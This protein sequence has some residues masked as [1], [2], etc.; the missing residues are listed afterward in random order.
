LAGRKKIIRRKA[1]AVAHCPHIEGLRLQDLFLWLQQHQEPRDYLPAE[2][3]LVKVGK[4]WLCNILSTVLP[5][6]F[7]DFV[8]QQID[9]RQEKHT[10]KQNKQVSICSLLHLP[11]RH[12]T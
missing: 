11:A 6:A 12:R 1:I 3:E 8:E 10:S 4:Q 5:D 2:E 7:D 9:R